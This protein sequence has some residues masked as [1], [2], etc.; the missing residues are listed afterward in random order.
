MAQLRREALPKLEALEKGDT[1]NLEALKRAARIADADA[2][3]VASAAKAFANEDTAKIAAQESQQLM[4][5]SKMLTE[6]ALPANRD[7]NQRPQWQEQQRA[8]MAQTE[9]LKKDLATLNELCAQILGRSFC[10]LGD[11]AATP[12]PQALNL[13]RSEFEAGTHTAADDL[14]NPAASVVFSG[15]KT[16]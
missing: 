10:A 3:A 6:N 8:L 9:A 1:E 4:R 16:S 7:A 14:F 2:D 13:F 5:Q 11:A 12:Y 15:V